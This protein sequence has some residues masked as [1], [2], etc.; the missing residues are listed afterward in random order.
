MIIV[1]LNCKPKEGASQY[2]YLTNVNEIHVT[3]TLE[4]MVKWLIAGYT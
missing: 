3:N 2:M 4:G 1:Y